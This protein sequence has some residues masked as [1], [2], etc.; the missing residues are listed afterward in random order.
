[1]FGLRKHPSAADLLAHAEGQVD[2]RATLSV[3][4]A[5]HVATCPRCLTEVEKA[6]ATLSLTAAA[7]P[8]EA[9]NALRARIQLAARDERRR[10]NTGFR[11]RFDPFGRRTRWALATGLAALAMFAS[12]NGL[13]EDSNVAGPVGMKRGPEGAQSLE[14]LRQ[15][16]PE[17][18]LLSAVVMSP[19]RIPRDP[20][21]RAHRRA[22]ETF[23][24]E[25]SEALAALERNPACVRAKQLVAA[26]RERLKET[27]KTLYVERSL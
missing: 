18:A 9:S 6:R 12:V 17:E 20:W 25:I 11:F 2:K 3:E 24:A 16:S 22:A 5:N 8:L 14:R 4:T 1:M 27:L 23:D 26:D 21:E 7:A 10:L 19:Q 13:L 15:S